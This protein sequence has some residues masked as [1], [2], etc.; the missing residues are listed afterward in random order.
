MNNNNKNS[1]KILPLGGSDNVTKNLFVYEWQD[2]Q[3]II[4][5]GIGFPEQDMLGVDLLIPDVSYLL[6]NRKKIH[7]IVL[8]HAH[9][10]HIAGLSYI[11][12]QLGKIPVYAS[13]LTAGFV[14]DDLAESKLKISL[15]VIKEND[16]LKLGPFMIEPVHVTHSVPDSFHLAIHTPVGL[17]YHG[18]DFKFD[19]KPIDNWPSNLQ[20]IASLGDQ[21]VLCLLSD[22]LRVERPGSSISESTIKDNLVR[23]IKKCQGR[24]LV[25]TIS[26]NLHRLQQAIDVA[27]S[28]D[29]RI[30]FVGRSIE[31]NI[32]TASKLGFIRLPEKMIISKKK[33]KDFPPNKVAIMI[34]GS[35]G[36]VESSLVRVANNEHSFVQVGIG[37]RVVFSSDAI[38]GNEQAVYR[39]I[40]QFLKIGADVVYSEVTDDLH[41]SGH[42]PQ[43]D[44]KLLIKLL[45]PQYLIPIGGAF[46][47]LH[48]YRRMAQEMNYR[49]DQIF[50]LRDGEAVSFD[51]SGQTKVKKEV[52]LKD[53]F[54]DGSR[55]GDVGPVV[56]D[57]RQRLAKDGI[58]VVAVPFD[59][60]SQKP[61]GEPEII[62]RGFVF[63][64]KSGQLIQEI[65]EKV[66]TC[67]P[68]TAKNSTSLCRQVEKNLYKFFLHQTGR[69]PLILCVLVKV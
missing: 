16:R 69:K 24:F 14:K 51:S 17:I 48:F 4:D 64:R 29:R 55:I 12:P 20:K 26:S 66:K 61:F 13:K 31:K 1:L 7:G 59:R 45:K 34:A 40:D 5:C 58:V 33:I 62:S 49:R 3:L 22:C 32:K 6:K 8:T 41:V 23:E 2:S 47:H 50:I 54:V 46:R 30:A 9:D 56:L 43:E 36:Q 57:D 44:L 39:T 52:N 37:D 11:L 35:Q 19:P 27:V 10:D 67:Y 42:A 28:F 18:S 38:P 21:K 60:Q 25:T 15:N 63:V 68:K 53:I 65:K